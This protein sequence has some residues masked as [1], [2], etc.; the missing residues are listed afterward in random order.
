M[1]Y[2]S[3]PKHK[4]GDYRVTSQQESFQERQRAREGPRRASE[5]RE[6]AGAW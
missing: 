6:R 2:M 1:N 4:K 3:V 5:V